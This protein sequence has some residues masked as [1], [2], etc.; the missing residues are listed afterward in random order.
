M[1]TTN[2]HDMKRLLVL[3]VLCMQLIVQS[4]YAFDPPGKFLGY[5]LGSKFTSHQQVVAYFEYLSN[6]LSTVQLTVYGK[7]WEGKPLVVAIVSTEENIKNLE[8]IRLNNLKRTGKIEGVPE[9]DDIAIVW[10]SYNVHG[11]EPSSTETAM[12]VLFTLASAGKGKYN[13]WLKNTIVIIDPCLNP[14]GRE[15][16]INWFGQVSG[17][18]PDPRI[19]S[20]EH[21]ENWPGGRVNHYLFDLNRDWA[22]LTQAESKDRIQLYHHWMPHVHIDFHEQGI[23]SNYYFAPAAKPFHERITPWQITFQRWVGDNNAKYFDEKDWLFFTEESFDLYYPG[24]GDTYPTFNGAIGMTYEMPGNSRAGLAVIT[25]RG[26]T[27]TLKDRINHHFV[28][29]MSTIEVSSSHAKELIE[30]F[31]KYFDIPDEQNK[32]H[33]YLIK[34]IKQQA[35]AQ[36]TALLDQHQISYSYCAAN[37][38]MNGV[39]YLT[40]EEEK[41]IAEKNDLIIDTRQPNSK[42]VHVLFDPFSIPA[43]SLTYDIT[44]WSLPFAYGLKTYI[45]REKPHDQPDIDV[46]ALR[47]DFQGKVYAF[48]VPWEDLGSV[49]FLSDLMAHNFRVRQAGKPISFQDR[50]FQEGCLIITKN[51]NKDKGKTWQ[52]QVIKLAQKHGVNIF[53]IIDPTDIRKSNIG[54]RYHSLI[55]R[56]EV[57]LAY[58]AGTYATNCGEVWYYFDQDIDFPVSRIPVKTLLTMDLSK[59][60]ILIFPDGYYNSLMGDNGFKNIEQWVRKGGRLVLF[61]GAVRSFTGKDKFSLK[62]HENTEEQDTSTT[63]HSVYKDSERDYL[64]NISQ[65]SLLSVQ[66]DNTHPLAYGYGESYVSLHSGGSLYEPLKGGWNVGY[67]GDPVKVV[68]GFTGQKLKSRLSGKLI[69][70]VEE[71][72]RGEVVYLL[73]DVLFR[74][75]WYGGKLLF[76]NAVFMH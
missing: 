32:E 10:L 31:T 35:T 21:H 59:Y 16:Y 50:S 46:K 8:K 4:V 70:G 72:G 55:K 63:G 40:S 54:S 1:K 53:P 52:D 42:L 18:K 22:W 64:T 34:N 61:Q 38:K 65:G 23:N 29:S 5:E 14:D 68:S 60:D 36:L 57:A 17:I 74:G 75:F 20:A 51:D 19:E 26:D 2:P 27:L 76:S 45:V 13:E 30:A 69:F 67:T 11:N 71:I 49:K 33:V 41:F 62:K 56:P 25:E 3:G 15:R 28:T 7:T 58:E 47:T 66:L 6:A 37:E 39:N 44:A 12:K 73:D 43:D 24:F 48:L 9:D